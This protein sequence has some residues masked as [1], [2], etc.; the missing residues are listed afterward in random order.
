MLVASLLIDD[1][2]MKRSILSIFEGSDVVK[3]LFVWTCLMTILLCSSCQSPLPGPVEEGLFSLIANWGKQLEKTT[4]HE[5]GIFI[6]P[7]SEGGFITLIQTENEQEQRLPTTNVKVCKLDA[8]G[9]MDWSDSP[10][11]TDHSIRTGVFVLPNPFS[12]NPEYLV[13]VQKTDLIRQETN[14]ELFYYDEDGTE[15]WHQEYLAN[16][17]DF[18]AGALFVSENAVMVYGRTDSTDG[19][20]FGKI[21]T[22]GYDG[23]VVPVNTADGQ[24]ENSITYDYQESDNGIKRIFTTIDSPELFFVGEANNTAGVQKIWMMRVYHFMPTFKSQTLFAHDDDINYY[25]GGM[26]RI[27]PDQFVMACTK[28]I[29]DEEQVA[30]YKFNSDASNE[31]MAVEILNEHEVNN[32]ILGDDKERSIGISHFVS[33][34]S[35]IAGVKAQNDA[36]SLNRFYLINTDQFEVREQNYRY[37]NDVIYNHL[38]KRGDQQL[39]GLTGWVPSQDSAEDKRTAGGRACWVEGL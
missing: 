21:Q 29:N 10:P 2:Q 33:D 27:G 22:T 4:D 5:E 28:E 13:G 3:R 23:F 7:T 31:L 9:D 15:R 20:F 11:L 26:C 18:L 1:R 12:S 35:L 8:N 24:P 37:R 16:G 14:I 6:Y 17:Q 34:N 36:V 19:L 30:F 25:F 39:Y 32:L 38:S